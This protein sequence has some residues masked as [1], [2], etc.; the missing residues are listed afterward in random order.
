MKRLML[1]LIAALLLAGG[2]SS[3]LRSHALFH[4]A[5]SGM[6]SIRELQTTGL[7]NA[8]PEQE[9]QDRSVLFAKEPAH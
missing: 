4:F 9:I 3:V 7:A 2:A 5:K 6:P 8:L 1:P